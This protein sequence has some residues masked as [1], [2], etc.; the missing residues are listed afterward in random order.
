MYPLYVLLVAAQC[1]VGSPTSIVES[2]ADRLARISKEHRID[3]VQTGRLP[4]HH[5][6]LLFVTFVYLCDVCACI[7]LCFCTT[8]SDD[9]CERLFL[10]SLSMLC[11]RASF[12]SCERL[13]I[14][15]GSLYVVR[16][17]I[18]LYNCMIF[19]ARFLR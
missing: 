19:D 1:T 14:I 15:F 13:F 8:P 2:T 11:V 9:P 4:L 10:L 16:L 3:S 6:E 7:F 12:N 5:P 17:C 18:F